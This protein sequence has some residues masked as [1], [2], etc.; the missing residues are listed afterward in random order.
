MK[1]VKATEQQ[2]LDRDLLTFEAWGKRLNLD[3]FLVRESVLRREKWSHENMTTWLLQDNLDQ[4]LASCE[5]FRMKSYIRHREIQT[6]GS[7]LGIASVYVEPRL[8]GNGYS[9][10]L[11]TELIN[12]LTTENEK[13]HACVLYSEV[14]EALYQKVGFCP[15]QSMEWVF[16]SDSSTVLSE[17]AEVCSITREHFIDHAHR[18]LC[19]PQSKFCIWPECDQIFWHI[20]RQD[21]YTSFLEKNNSNIVGIATN[22][23]WIIWMI[24]YKYDVLRIL[25]SSLKNSADADALIKKARQ[26]AYK[27]GLLEVRLW[28]TSE[29][30]SCGADVWTAREFVARTDAIAMI[31]PLAS[32]IRPENWGEIQRAIWV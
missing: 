13:F 12:H 6:L 30:L 5:T 18:Y 22:D 19:P 1:I 16:P 31:L 2:K 9:S 7:T 29:T 32:E 3:Q 28:S 4:P 20:K 8:R 14:G 10:A 17:P 15:V 27:M 11:L 25:V 26:F 24:D 21:L 23:S